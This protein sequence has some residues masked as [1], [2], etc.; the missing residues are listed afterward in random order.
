M[1]FRYL[2]SCSAV[3][4]TLHRFLNLMKTGYP[5]CLNLTMN[6]QALLNTCR[7]VP[8]AVLLCFAGAYCQFLSLLNMYFVRTCE[9]QSCGRQG[10]SA[11]TPIVDAHQC[12]SYLQSYTW[13]SRTRPHHNSR[14]AHRHMIIPR[15]FIRYNKQRAYSPPHAVSA[16]Y[17]S[18]SLGCVHRAMSFTL[19]AHAATGHGHQSCC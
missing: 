17:A 19:A 16:C 15:S 5:A 12:L 3:L 1:A 2:N 4:C 10:L 7:G 18:S 6:Q 9:L 11:G 8:H 13:T 14:P